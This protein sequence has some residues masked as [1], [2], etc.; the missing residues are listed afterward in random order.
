MRIARERLHFVGI[1][2]IGMSG[3]AELLHNMGAT[4]TGSDLS[5][6]AMTERLKS[7]GIRIFQ[8]HVE[9]NV[10][11]VDVVVYSSAVQRENPELA[12]ARARKIPTIP[13]AEILAEV[14][15]L[16]RGIAVG[17]SHGKTT[18]TSL[19]ASIFIHAQMD[20]TI[21]VGGRLDL[22]KSTSLLGQGPWLIAEADESDGS[23]LKLSPEIAI[24]TNVDNDHLDHYKTFENLQNA[25]VEFAR[26]VPFYGLS[27][28]CG[29]DPLVRKIF[30]GFNKRIVFYG[31]REENDYFIRLKDARAIIFKR[32]EKEEPQEIGSFAL[33]IPGKHNVLNALSAFVVGMEAG[34][35]AETC[36]KGLELYQG[37]DRRLQ[38][39]GELKGVL[40]YDDYG[41]H[42][43]EIK[44]VI[45]ALKEKFPERRLVL[46]F[47]P[48]RYSRTQFCWDQFRDC[49]EGADLLM[50]T[51]IYAA[52][53]KPIFGIEGKT[54]L[55]HVQ[56]VKEKNFISLWKDSV[57]EIQKRL[58]A[59]DLVVTLGAGDI[60]KLGP[61]LLKV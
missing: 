15:R 58:K 39:K 1:G 30:E 8:G 21:V 50:M 44:A 17:G 33:Q 25:F 23:F 4:V 20:P 11:D 18:T 48:H 34:L 22:I 26:K 6:N 51:E 45:Q 5:T 12:N 49:F 24:I 57:S 16:K 46:I 56:N 52:G 54:L 47:Q 61:E 40:V 42:P 35:S 19:L 2:G 3:L 9:E 41:H 10:G 31:F 37:V 36:I 60:S 43:T 28:V 59:N 13:R 55:S 38:K 14:M 53:E 27:V 7:L 29:D 32:T